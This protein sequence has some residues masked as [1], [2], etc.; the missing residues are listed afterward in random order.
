MKK[1]ISVAI[2]IFLL[3]S[4]F[5]V[6][7][8]SEDTP[9]IP[10]GYTPIY[11]KDDLDEV[12]LNL[13]GKYILMNDIV[14]TDAD[15]AQGGGFYNSG[16]GFVPIPKF[17]GVFDGNGFT[18][19]NLYINLPSVDNVGLF[20][21]SDGGKVRNLTLY[22]AN[23]TGKDYV[24]AIFGKKE[25]TNDYVSVSKCTV[26]G[27]VT[28]NENVGGIMGYADSNNTIED[29]YN[30]AN[31]TGVNYVGGACGY[32]RFSY[33]ERSANFGT[34]TATGS[35]GCA[36]GLVGYSYGTGSNYSV[37]KNCYNAGNVVGAGNGSSY[38]PGAYGIGYGR[39]SSVYTCYSVGNSYYGD[40]WQNINS[41]F[42]S[43][44]VDP[45]QS[46]S[47]YARS[48]DQMIKRT[49]Y[50]SWDFDTIWTIDNTADYP[51]P[52]FLANPKP[53]EPIP[54]CEHANTELV[55]AAD[56]TCTEN[57]YSGDL[58][59][60]DCGATIEEG[61]VITALGHDYIDHPAKAPTCSA[62]GWNAYQ[63]CSRCTYTNYEE[64]SA[65]ENNHVNTEEIPETESTCF[66]PGY[67]AGVYCNDCKQFISGHAEKALTE[68]V[69]NNG[70]VLRE[71]T[72]NQKGLVKY[73]CTAEGC[74]ATETRETAFA[75]DNHNYVPTVTNP[76]CTAQGF[77]TYTCSRCGSNYKDDYVA[78]LGHE[79]QATVTAATC[80]EGGYTT[81]T[82]VRGDHTY[83]DNKTAALGHRD[84]DG[85]GYCDRCFSKLPNGGNASG[86]SNVYEFLIQ[87]F[88][89]LINFFRSIFK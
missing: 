58:V 54:P 7:V 74:G 71:A 34:I 48:Y 69:W 45:S 83:V 65:N 1:I 60:S 55:N 47:T 84:G 27:S 88:R 39:G 42:L 25:S 12:R 59:C 31:V 32:Q 46:T 53:E 3:L 10:E 2:C 19:Y 78:A 37:V 86:I 70:E 73:T 49:N 41:Y 79:Y 22:Q 40:G 11:T 21:A 8:F 30:M 72:C 77:T 67:T 87:F 75:P 23:I 26:Y 4:A 17:T 63:T 44:S 81:F 68:H 76:T 80:T 89:M 36:G 62:V 14:F 57:G 9:E 13:S 16:K 6:I 35:S 43:D 24:G 51:F 66:T 5:P 56:A 20:K 18:I 15:Y 82:C 61:S 33:V 52:T 28:G 85:D 38:V 50:S 64:L 29:C